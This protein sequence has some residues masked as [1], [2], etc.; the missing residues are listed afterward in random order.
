MAEHPKYKLLGQNYVLPDMV[1]TRDVYAISASDRVE[2]SMKARI[3][4]PDAMLKGAGDWTTI[5][6]PVTRTGFLPP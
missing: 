6:P 4:N 5:H 1:A 2:P 3:D